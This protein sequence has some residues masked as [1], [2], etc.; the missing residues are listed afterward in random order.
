VKALLFDL[1]ETLIEEEEPVVAALH[2]TAGSARRHHGLEA[3]ALAQA[4]RVQAR[5]LCRRGRCIDTASRLGLAPPRDSGVVLT[6]SAARWR[7]CVRGRRLTGIR[8]GQK[9]LRILVLRTSDSPKSS[10]SV[11]G[12]SGVR[13]TRC[14]AIRFRRWSGPG[15]RTTSSR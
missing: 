13:A 5:E 3:D 10:L 2:A 15:A 8:R 7:A 12:A 9:R 14:L 1:D 6:G 4:V 11:S